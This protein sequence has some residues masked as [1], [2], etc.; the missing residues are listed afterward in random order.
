LDHGARLNS[1]PLLLGDTTEGVI[2]LLDL[3][4]GWVLQRGDESEGVINCSSSF[5]VLSDEVLVV[6]MS[7]LSE[8]GFL[9]K[10]LPVMVN[11]LVDFSN[12]V[13]NLGESWLEEVE[14]GIF[15]SSHILIGILDFLIV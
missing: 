1:A 7:L 9:G 2:D 13:S 15:S 6:F 12:V 14:D 3:E 5:V 10:V 4:E 8:E 11:V